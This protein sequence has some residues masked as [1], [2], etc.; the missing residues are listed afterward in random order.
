MF[1]RDQHEKS[2][3]RRD[4][5]AGTATFCAAAVLVRSRTASAAATVRKV[6]KEA[7]SYMAAPLGRKPCSECANFIPGP[8]AAK[9]GTCA[10]VA[11][12]ISRGGHCILWSPRKPGGCA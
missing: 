5:L 10:V 4:I 1:R 6:R 8:N 12:T 9:E 3:S 2:V 11:G 7:V